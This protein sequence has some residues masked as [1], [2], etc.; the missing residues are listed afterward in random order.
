[1]DRQVVDL[2]QEEGEP[3]LQGRGVEAVDVVDG[4]RHDAPAVTR[5]E[6]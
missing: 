3:L 6:S 5:N 4:D 1:M 2:L